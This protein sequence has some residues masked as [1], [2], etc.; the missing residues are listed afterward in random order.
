LTYEEN[1]GNTVTHR[2]F[3]VLSDVKFLPA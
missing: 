1:T 3:T 2:G